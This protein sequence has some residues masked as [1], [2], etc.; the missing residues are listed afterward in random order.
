MT[1]C[2]GRHPLGVGPSPQQLM[3]SHF[4]HY[5]KPPNQHVRVVRVD[6]RQR[7]WAGAGVVLHEYN[8]QRKKRLLRLQGVFDRVEV[9]EG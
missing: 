9:K 5:G 6:E 2:G 7:L 8:S 4:G 3:S 1:C